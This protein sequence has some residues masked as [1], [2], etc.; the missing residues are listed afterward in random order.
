MHIRPVPL[1]GK[2]VGP[3]YS[4]PKFTWPMWCTSS[5]AVDGQVD[6]PPFYDAY[7]ILCRPH[8]KGHDTGKLILKITKFAVINHFLLYI[9]LCKWSQSS[10]PELQNQGNWKVRMLVAIVENCIFFLLSL[11]FTQRDF[12]LRILPLTRHLASGHV[13]DKMLPRAGCI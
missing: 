9:N 7:C 5:A 4:G 6:I 12:S 13:V 1:T 2:Y 11:D 8:N 3:P 10:Q